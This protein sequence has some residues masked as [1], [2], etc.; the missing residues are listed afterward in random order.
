MSPSPERG[1]FCGLLSLPWDFHLKSGGIWLRLKGF[2]F[3]TMRVDGGV[4]TR[5]CVLAGHQNVHSPLV[6]TSLLA[7]ERHRSAVAELGS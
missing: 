7:I 5:S 4:F 2:V 6:M 1:G 3:V